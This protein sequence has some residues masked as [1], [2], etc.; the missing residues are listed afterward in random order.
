MH[1]SESGEAFFL[2]PDF[3]SFQADTSLGGASGSGVSCG[4]RS[5]SGTWRRFTRMRVQVETAAHGVNQNVINSQMPGGLR[6]SCFPSLEAGHR[7]FF[8]LRVGD[9]DERHLLAAPASL[10]R[11]LRASARAHAR[12]FPLHLAEMR[13]PGRIAQPSRLIPCR[14]LQQLHPGSPRA[15][16]S[17]A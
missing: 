8:A 2:A 4:G 10:P 12:R 11:R 5:L 1:Y 9:H 6:M 14:H 16:P 17:S 15:R 7:G 3:L 13:R